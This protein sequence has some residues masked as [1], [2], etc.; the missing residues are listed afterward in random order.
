MNISNK[1][2]SEITVYMK[3]AKYVP[4]LNRRET[5][6]ELVTRNKNMH[7]KKYPELKGEIEE[8]YKLVH[9]KKVLPSMRSMQ[10]AGKSI[11]ISPNR[12]YNCAFLPIDAVESFS[13]TMFLLLGGTGVGY[14]VQKHHVEK[15]QPINKPYAKRK[16]RFLI[17]DSIEGWA[18]SIKVLMKSYIG[19]KRSSTIEFDFSDI[20]AKGA[21]LVTSGGKAPGPQPLKECIVKI[22]GILE[23]KSDGEK[24]TTLETHDIVCHIADAVLAGGIRRAALISL[25]SAD[26]DE[27]I[28]C[29]SGNWWETN[30][31]RGRSNNSA[32]LIRHKITKQFFMELW[33]RIELSGAGEPGI[34]LS[35]DKEWG[36]NPCCEIALR[37]FQFCNLCEVNV[38][39]IESQEDL[40]ERVKAAA[41]IGTL[42]AG[43]TDFHYLREIWQETTEKDALI[44][45]SMTGI[46]SGVVLGYDLEKSADIVKRENSKVAKLIGINKSARCTTV[47]PAGTTSLTLGTSSGIH[48][49]HNDY[50]IRRIRVGKNES[51]YKYLI[52]NHPELLEDD[53]FRA[54]DTA[55]I[56]IPQKAPKG[57]IL[58]TESPFDLLERVKKV[59]TEWVKS[60]HRN[61]SNTHNVSATISL[62][63]EDWGLA[64][65]WMWTNKEHYNGLSVLPYNGGTY[66]Q[67]PFED[68]TEDTYNEM[69]KHLNNIDLSLIVEETDETDLSG[70]LACAGG[71]CEIN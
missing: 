1:I 42:Q 45:V 66:T 7:I 21:R 18:D 59:A 13:E 37:P 5:W 24:L 14:S 49:W 67:A 33:K 34:Y 10:F 36:T 3:Y 32:V 70:E 43:Y 62:K 46:G 71:A 22:T 8:K 28:S 40:N 29:K 52:V 68:I 51:I 9:D 4:E 64:G 61:G 30:P 54:H 60:G 57:S 31:Q 25:F 69:L 41:F 50:Y 27:M 55:I 58:R 6:D 23:N 12:V 15:L 26:D 2:L 63:E 19:D 16:R 11:E 56:T 38:S 44:G 65:E 35:N 17:G 47:K 20:R 48:A 53:F 39:N